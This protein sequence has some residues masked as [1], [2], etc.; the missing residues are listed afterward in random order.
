MV[1][2]DQPV[3]I[4]F[5]DAKTLRE[6]VSIGQPQVHSASLH[7]TMKRSFQGNGH[8]GRATQANESCEIQITMSIC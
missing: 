8:G 4:S 2:I 1:G 6:L 5:R 7:R 3:A